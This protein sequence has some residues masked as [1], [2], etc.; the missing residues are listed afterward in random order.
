M[1]RGTP[2][3]RSCLNASKPR[4]IKPLTY[5]FL[6]AF[7]TLLFTPS[8][9]GLP[10]YARQTGQRCAACHVGGNWPQLTPWGRFFKLGGYA[11]GKSF[12]DREGF[13]YVPLGALLRSGITWAA[14]PKNSQGQTVIQD[15]GTPEFYNAFGEL[16]TKIT[17][18]AGVFAEYGVNNTFPGWKGVQGPLDMRATHF[19]HPGD[20]EL[21][22]GFD[23]NN[24]PTLQ[25][26]WNTIPGWSY[27]YYG[28]PQAPGSPAS[29]MIG[30][31]SNAVGSVGA[32]AV[33]DRQFYVEFSAYRVANNFFR[34]MSGGV[35]F[36]KGAPYV[37]GWNPYWRAYWTKDHGPNVWMVGTFGLQ[38]NLFPNSAFPHGPT[39]TFDDTGVDAQYQYLG[40]T[41]KLTVRASYIYEDQNWGGSYAL[42]N[43]SV[44]KGNLKTVNLSSSFALRDTW[45][46]TAGYLLNNGSNNAALYGITNPSGQLISNK[47]NTTQYELEVDRTLTQNILLMLKYTGFAKFNG[48]AGNIDGLGRQASDN[49]TLWVNFFFAF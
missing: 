26:V 42:G 16:G 18:W 32:Y 9:Y 3:N 22:V 38:S 39:N 5:V 13:E 28:S 11:A 27:P 36:Q 1:L 35:S 2:K 6:L 25:D 15:N 12:V 37:Q 14:Q 43:S 48:R 8:A 47:P 23:M 49:N 45:T 41:H 21:L 46:F 4:R 29:P 30:N 40:D 44:P 31:L 17:D 10:S 19:F 33:F 24:S 34:F 7:A 20:H